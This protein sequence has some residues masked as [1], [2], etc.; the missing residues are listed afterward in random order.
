M[1]LTQSGGIEGLLDG[2]DHRCAIIGMNARQEQVVRDL[3]VRGKP[4]S[5]LHSA[6]Q[7]SSCVIGSCSKVPT[8]KASWAAASALR[9]RASPW[10]KHHPECLVEQAVNVSLASALAMAEAVLL[11]ELGSRT[12]AEVRQD[13]EGLRSEHLG[14]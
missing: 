13:L 4:K 8:P 7:Y 1:E 9:A 10:A 3:R 11:Q 12:L 2:L 5:A 14:A 6:A